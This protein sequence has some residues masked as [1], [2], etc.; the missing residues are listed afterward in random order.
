MCVN[1]FGTLRNLTQAHMHLCVN[2]AR[3]V[4]IEDARDVGLPILPIHSPIIV[5]TVRFPTQAVWS[6]YIIQSNPSS[7]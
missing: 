2:V 5:T 4:H 6:T 7:C 1:Y 3:L